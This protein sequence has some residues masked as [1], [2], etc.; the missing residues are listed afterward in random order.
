MPLHRSPLAR[1]LA[2]QSLLWLTALDRM[3]VWGDEQFTLDTIARPWSEIPGALRRDIHPPLYYFLAKLWMMLR[4]S[5]SE[6][7]W[8]GLSP[9]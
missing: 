2:C 7:V 8:H 9:P 4:P 1:A 3:P 5:A 6:I